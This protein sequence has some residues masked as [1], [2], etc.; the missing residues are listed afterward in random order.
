M[1]R[2]N[3]ILTLLAFHLCSSGAWGSDDSP[4]VFLSQ[5]GSMVL[6][7]IPYGEAGVSLQNPSVPRIL[8]EWPSE[9]A[10]P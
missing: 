1:R 3:I 7:P 2:I 6:N 10:V 8:Q 9:R 5:E 4:F